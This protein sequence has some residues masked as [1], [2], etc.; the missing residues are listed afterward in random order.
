MMDQKQQEQSKRYLETQVKTATREQL[1]ILLFD[2]ALRFCSLAKDAMAQN[3]VEAMSNHLI[4]AQRIVVELMSSLDRRVGDAV[5]SNLIQLYKFTYLRLVN[6]N[7]ERD[8]AAIDEA[9]GILEHLKET[10]QQAIEKMLSDGKK[11]ID[12][13]PHHLGE[14][15]GLDVSG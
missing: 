6:A 15:R 9:T 13:A 7:V 5:Y 14:S 12:L 4:R 10:W 3:D 1:L 2:G 11:R 8:A